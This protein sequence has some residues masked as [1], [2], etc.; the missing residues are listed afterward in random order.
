MPSSSSSSSSS[1]SLSN[2]N[3]RLGLAFTFLGAAARG[4]WAFSTLSNYLQGMTRSVFSVGLA[5]G[6]QGV[7][8]ALVALVAGWY[9][10]KFRRDLV[11]KCA[12]MLGLLTVA[13]MFVT[14]F[15]PGWDFHN[16]GDPVWTW[17]DASVRYPMFV[18]ALAFWGA[19]QGVWNTSLETIFADSIPLGERSLYNT[20]KFVLQL[21]ASIS[22][23]IGAIVLF[24]LTG[25]NW[26]QHTLTTVFAG[27]LVATIPSIVCLFFFRDDLTLPGGGGERVSG[28][29]SSFSARGRGHGEAASGMAKYGHA[30]G[31]GSSG[32]SSRG[33]G[34]SNLAAVST[35]TAQDE[36]KSSYVPPRP[37]QGLA[38]HGQHTT[39]R[40]GGG[41]S[42][43]VDG[44]TNDATQNGHTA[45]RPPS[46]WRRCCVSS[47]RVPHVI[48]GSDLISGF[49]S[50]MTVKFFPLFFSKKLMLSPIGTNCIYIAVPMFM[51][52]ASLIAQRLSMKFGR[53]Q[54]SILYAYVGAVALVGMWILGWV[55]DDDWEHVAGGLVLPLYFFSTVQHCV[56]PL[57]KSILMDFVP[58]GQR[59]RW[60]SLDSVTRFGWSGSAVLGGWIVDRLNY[61]WSFL[62]TAVIQVTAASMLAVLLETVPLERPGAGAGGTGPGGV[63]GASTQADQVARSQG[64]TI[65]MELTD[66][67]L[68]AGSSSAPGPLA[69][70][71]ASSRRPI[72]NQRNGVDME[73]GSGGGGGSSTGRPVARNNSFNNLARSWNSDSAGSNFELRRASIMNRD[74]QGVSRSHEQQRSLSWNDARQ[75]RRDQALLLDTESIVSESVFNAFAAMQSPLMNSFLRREDSP[76]MVGCGAGR[77]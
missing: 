50:G 25:N 54:V 7:A 62:I 47:A 51:M 57:K 73:V 41:G 53:V 16:P 65:P 64:R 3:I 67:L 36:S 30:G 71:K 42:G 24:V 45:S 46:C 17:M 39:I 34:S 9:A 61:G 49:G 26:G 29:N 15:V 18:A 21:L 11:L 31:N 59:A 72:L 10:D 76:D 1:S 56:R 44:G 74:G 32:S 66:P 60:N 77:G 68:G 69:G 4:I 40:G 20:R 43:T 6:V 5:E 52:A 63:S 48:V 22:G 8:Q 38:P 14:L 12:G 28:G 70:I 75:V 19:Y 58:K 55:A 35:K 13:F 27:G 23:P 2:R 33:G 37:A